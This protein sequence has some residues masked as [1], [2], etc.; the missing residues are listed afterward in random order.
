[1]TLHDDSKHLITI[2][3]HCGLYQYNRLPFRF[4]SVPTLFQRAMDTLLQGI[5]NVL[6]YIN[7]ILVTG[8]TL[9]QHL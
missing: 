5:P 7:D 1:M 3:T 2:N 9:T 6:Y 8:A 4:P